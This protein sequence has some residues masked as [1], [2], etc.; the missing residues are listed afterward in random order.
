MAYSATKASEIE[1]TEYLGYCT[2]EISKTVNQCYI[3]VTIDRVV[4]QIT[5]GLAANKII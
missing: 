3:P 5:Y 4:I 1:H 2:K